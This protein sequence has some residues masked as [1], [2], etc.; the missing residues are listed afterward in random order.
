[1]PEEHYIMPI[2][3]WNSGVRT[4]IQNG[5][6][7]FSQHSH[8]SGPF[9]LKSRCPNYDE[10]MWQRVWDSVKRLCVRHECHNCPS[11]GGAFHQFLIVEG[12][13]LD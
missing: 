9:L 2:I 4:G 12:D 13:D 6:L 1:M 10:D 8:R 5:V 3:I 7:P 11:P